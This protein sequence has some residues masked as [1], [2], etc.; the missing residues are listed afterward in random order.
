[1]QTDDKNLQ[2][3]SNSPTLKWA[4]NIQAIFNCWFSN[5]K[6]FIIFEMAA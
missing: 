2:R 3:D 5:S 1:M 6:K 4:D